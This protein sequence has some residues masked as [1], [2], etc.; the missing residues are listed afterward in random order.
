MREHVIL[1][2]VEEPFSSRL[3]ETWLRKVART[4]LAGE[5]VPAAELDVLVTDDAT[6][7]ELNRTYA[8]EDEPTDVLSFSLQEGEQMVAAPDGLLHLGEVII[9]YPTAERQA[10]ERGHP[11]QRE[12]A[13]LLI[14]GVLHLL[15]Y[16]H[17]LPEEERLM[18]A[19]ENLYLGRAPAP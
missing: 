9:S 18:Q 6:V 10:R 2:S 14:H 17:A 11:V 13:H 19:R 3:D 8:G 5:G 4:V 1:V 12:V 7:Q 16:D 15:G